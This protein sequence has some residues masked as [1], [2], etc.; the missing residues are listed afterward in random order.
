MIRGMLENL[1]PTYYCLRCHTPL[2]KSETVRFMGRSTEIRC[3]TCGLTMFGRELLGGEGVDEP[4]LN[5]LKAAPSPPASAQAK[6][7]QEESPHRLTVSL[8]PGAAGAVRMGRVRAIAMTL[9][10]GGWLVVLPLGLANVL[11]EGDWIIAAILV[12]AIGVLAGALYAILR[13]CFGR[14]EVTLDD[15]GVTIVRG[16]GP[17]QR[18]STLRA[19]QIELVRLARTGRRRYGLQSQW[20]YAVEVRGTRT[21]IRFAHQL[22]EAEQRWLRDELAAFI[23]SHVHS[24]LRAFVHAT[25][26]RAVVE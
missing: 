11:I 14:D 24:P 3:D 6:V 21:R 12:V 19:D 10:L 22:D 15:R 5:E 1:A 23:I 17:L 18:R 8:G 4:K 9:L 25:A 2:D 16:L 7:W 20:T 13:S 26:G